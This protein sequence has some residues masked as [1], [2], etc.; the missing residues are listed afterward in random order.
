[1]LIFFILL[2]VFTP[3]SST[4][5]NFVLSSTFSLQRATLNAGNSFFENLDVF[6]NAKEIKE[7]IRRLR[8]ENMELLARL[9]KLKEIK[10][11][12]EALREILKIDYYTEKEFVFGEVAGK[13]LA[14]QHII[15]RH[16]RDVQEGDPVITPEGILIGVVEEVHDGFSTVKLITSK[17]SSFEVKVQNE[18][19]P[20][21]VLEGTGEKTLL[22]NF[23]PKDKRVARGDAVVSLAYEKTATSG[24]LI[25][26]ILEVKKNDV[27]AFNQA[28]VWQGVDYRYLDYL[29]IMKR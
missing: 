18:D 29:L 12:N 8:K 22:L 20:I 23:L 5:K 1:M 7:E 4:I 6:Q 28:I 3:L 10:K 15:V 13:D 14:K 27:E 17:G 26:R 25:G 9:S 24:V 19:E 16:E 2:N 21:G 11:E